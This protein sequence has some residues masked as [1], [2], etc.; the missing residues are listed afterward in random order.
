VQSCFP[1]ALSLRIV[2]GARAGGIGAVLGSRS[3]MRLAIANNRMMRDCEGLGQLVGLR[4]WYITYCGRLRDVAALS[5]L[6]D[7]R[8]LQVTSCRQLR[9]ASLAPSLA[10]MAQ[11][12]S[13]RLWDNAIGAAGAASLAPSLALMAQLTSLGLGGNAIGA[14]GLCHRSRVFLRGLL[15]SAG[16][17]P[18]SPA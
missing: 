4:S 11:L 9:A 7:L 16:A 18:T 17:P 12:T 14:A 13:L 1:R 3:V 6:V 10:Q 5:A 2:G 15:G 8:T